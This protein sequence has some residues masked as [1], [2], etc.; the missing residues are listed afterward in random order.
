[1]SHSVAKTG[2]NQR[3]KSNV[4]QFPA[5]PFGTQCDQQTLHLNLVEGRLWRGNRLIVLRPKAL[6]LLLCLAEHRQ[7]LMTQQILLEAVWPDVCVNEGEVR[8][9]VCDLRSAL[10]DDAKAPTF[11]ETVPRRGYRFIGELDISGPAEPLTHL[12]PPVQ[13]INSGHLELR[14]RLL[15]A[16]AGERQVVIV[17]DESCS[18]ETP[19]FDTFFDEL[20]SRRDLLLGRGRCLDW[21]GESEIYQSWLD[22]L[23]QM[24]NGSHGAS[25]VTCMRRYAPSWLSRL[26]TLLGIGS[27]AVRLS[28]YSSFEPRPRELAAA[29]EA[30]SASGTLILCLEGLHRA[31]PA[32]LDLLNYMARRSGPARVLLLASYRSERSVSVIA[33][34]TALQREGRCSTLSF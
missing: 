24:G 23:E 9:T 3:I 20:S 16:Q 18:G 8:H 7:Q 26:P 14:R 29:L 10:G 17:D 21:S 33:L 25:F 15:K 27:P 11:I 13:V 32:T 22:I 12:A 2:P 28:T 30:L 5:T 34:H 1:M 4:R 19:L 31:D 6:F